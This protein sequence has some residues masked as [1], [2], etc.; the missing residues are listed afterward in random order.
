MTVGLNISDGRLH[1]RVGSVEETTL[2]RIYFIKQ[3]VGYGLKIL[4]QQ[5]L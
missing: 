5:Y 2:S 3:V 4:K 1:G